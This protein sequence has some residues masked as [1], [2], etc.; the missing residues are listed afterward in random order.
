MIFLFSNL[1]PQVLEES[2][3][4]VKEIPGIVS[5]VEKNIAWIESSMKVDLGLKSAISSYFDKQSMEAT[6]KD[7][8]ENLRNAGIVLGKIFIALV[9]SYVFIIDRN[10]IAGYLETV[11]RG[12]FA[13]LYQ[14][15]AVILTKIGK[16]FGLIFKAQAFIALVNALLTTL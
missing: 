2:K 6:A 7:V 3:S 5:D 12:N 1:V 8:F 11:K 10:K 9:L 13:F 14:E 16:G 15:Y 4:I